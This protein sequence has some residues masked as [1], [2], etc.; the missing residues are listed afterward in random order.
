[1][2]LCSNK[3]IDVVILNANSASEM[4]RV[5]NHRKKMLLSKG[6]KSKMNI[7]GFAF[8]TSPLLLC[9]HIW[10]EKDKIPER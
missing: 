6:I 8:C 10:N 9:T 3:E 4:E 5:I 7:I 2:M 1:M